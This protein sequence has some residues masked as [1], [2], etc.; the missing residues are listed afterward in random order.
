MR[1]ESLH[2]NI[3][4]HGKAPYVIKPS[5]ESGSAGVRYA[6]TAEEAERFLAEN[7][8]SDHWI[9]KNIWKVRLIPSK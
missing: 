6:A 8:D 4:P 3:T 9:I 2:P 7:E 5:G 1:P